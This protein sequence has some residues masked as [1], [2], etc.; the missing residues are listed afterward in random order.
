[1]YRYIIKISQQLKK[2]T[3]NNYRLFCSSSAHNAEVT[4]TSTQRV[5]AN[6]QMR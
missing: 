2:K 5:Y 6:T 3:Y 4:K 1:M